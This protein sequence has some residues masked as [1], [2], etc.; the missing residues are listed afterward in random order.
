MTHCNKGDDYPLE[1]VQF[2]FT[3]GRINFIFKTK[4]LGK[5]DVGSFR[6]IQ[7]FFVT[8]TKEMTILWKI[9]HFFFIFKTKEIGK[10]DVRPFRKLRICTL[11]NSSRTFNEGKSKR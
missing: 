10:H 8:V 6:K 9:I 4:E 1:I 5:H 11:R 2:L 7:I 3:K